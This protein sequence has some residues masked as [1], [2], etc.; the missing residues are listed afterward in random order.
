MRRVGAEVRARPRGAWPARR[1]RRRPSARRPGRHGAVRSCRQPPAPGPAP[2]R[3]G[4]PRPPVSPRRRPAPRPRVRSA[5]QAAPWQ[6]ISSRALNTS[7]TSQR[8]SDSC[9]ASAS[10]PPPSPCRRSHRSPR[11]RPRRRSVRLSFGLRR[12][13]PAIPAG[14]RPRQLLVAELGLHPGVAPAHRPLGLL[15]VRRLV[16]DVAGAEREHPGTVAPSPSTS[17]GPSPHTQGND[18]PDFCTISRPCSSM[19]LTMAAISSLC[20]RTATIRDESRPL[21]RSTMFPA[22]STSGSP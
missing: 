5:Y 2:P 9:S 3:S 15:L 19:R 16:G 4:T 14:R 6:P 1:R 21:M 12:A 10:S 20:A 18:P 13:R 22:A 8:G 17:T 11:T 7:S